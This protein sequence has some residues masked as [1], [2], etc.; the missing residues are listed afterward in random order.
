MSEIGL[1]EAIR[2]LRK[3]LEIS[4]KGAT[5]EEIRFEVGEINLE[6]QVTMEKTIGGEV[7]FWVVS[8][9]GARTVT[10]SHSVA[11]SLTPHRKH[12]NGPVVLGNDMEIQ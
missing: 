6:F 1:H 5:G 12:T 7:N 3:E 10:K 11:I 9:D 8:G 4:I 2:S